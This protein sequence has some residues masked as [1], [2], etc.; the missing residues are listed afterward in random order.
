MATR[1]D[2]RRRGYGGRVLRALL[3]E[4]GARGLTGYWLLVMAS[5][6]G[7]RELY[8]RAGFRETGRYLYRQDRPKRH[9]T[10]C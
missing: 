10:G 6:A 7:A 3:H 1:P 4:G 8:A 9:L 2:A 5:N